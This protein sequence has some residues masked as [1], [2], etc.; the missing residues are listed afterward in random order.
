MSRMLVYDLS[1]IAYICAYQ[2]KT[3]LTDSADPAGIIYEQCIHYLKRLYRRF[4]PD[5]VIC[6]CDGQHYWRREIYP[7]YKAH[8]PNTEL[9]QWV[10]AAISIFKQ[11]FAHLCLEVMHCEADDIIFAI[12]LYARCSVTIVSSDQDFVQLISERV[13]LFDP[14]KSQYRVA[15]KNQAM[16]LFIKCMRGDKS[17]NIFSAYPYVSTKRIESAF[18]SERSLALLMATPK[19]DG[20]TVF[21]DYQRNRQLID[22]SCLPDELKQTIKRDFIK[23]LKVNSGVKG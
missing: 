12:S 20:R 9:K 2:R 16:A 1:N 22:L 10:K 5:R 23:H 4:K 3:D 6:A 7:D 18:K 17:D 13:T 21:D 14:N 19:A 8:R 11:D 15:P